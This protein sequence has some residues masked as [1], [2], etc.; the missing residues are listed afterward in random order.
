M[1][2]DEKKGR[3]GVFEDAHKLYVAMRGQ[4]DYSALCRVIKSEIEEFVKC[5]LLL[6]ARYNTDSKALEMV[7]GTDPSYGYGTHFSVDE[8]SGAWISRQRGCKLSLFPKVD[9]APQFLQDIGEKWHIQTATVYMGDDHL[10]VWDIL[11]MGMSELAEDMQI[12][13]KQ[14]LEYALRG[15]MYILNMLYQISEIAIVKSDIKAIF[16]LAPVGIMIIESDGAI[17]DANNQTLSILGGDVPLEPLIGESVLT[18]KHL[19]GTGLDLLIQKTL[20]GQ[21][22]EN[23]NFK[24]KGE[25]GKLTHLHI[26]LRPVTK[27]DG[28]IMAICVMTDITQQMRMQH[29]LDRSYRTLMEAFQ[30]LQKAD[31]MKSRFIDVVS[32][33]LRTP[34][35]VMRGYI[36]YLEGEYKTKLDP[37]I[38]SKMKIMKAN[39]DRMY[40]LVESMLD[41][42]QIEKGGLTISKQ[43]SSIKA[44]VEEVVASHRALSVEK[45][46]E[47]TIIQVGEIGTSKFDV[48][49]MRDALKNIIN[50][51]I[52]YTPDGGKVQVG[53]ADEGKMI[54]IWVRDNGIGIPTSDLEKIFDKFHIST[55]EELARQVDRIGLGLPITKGIIEGHGGKIWV[56]SEIGKGSVFHIN[57]PKE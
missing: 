17:T 46:Q 14:N 13:Q 38:L 35:T 48:K 9:D 56:E 44:L 2:E 57:I 8:S 52:I 6:Y 45:R 7:A 18:G 27:A 55:A 24:L 33:E 22:I 51:A 31:T 1:A 10:P 34:L 54:H 49:K 5:D 39:A 32:H 3:I 11:I 20:E 50:N 28:S 16:E 37:K 53:L 40:D 15:A 23:N 21:E 19:K 43:E 42:A 30:E 47:L 4:L 36:E 26:K 29:Q 25:G 12:E 41:V